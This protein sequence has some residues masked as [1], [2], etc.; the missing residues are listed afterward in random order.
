[1]MKERALI[2]EMSLDQ[3]FAA[4]RMVGEQPEMNSVT[5]QFHLIGCD[6]ELGTLTV[7]RNPAATRWMTTVG[8]AQG[9]RYY[10][11][12]AHGQTASEALAKIERYCHWWLGM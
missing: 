10:A 9:A 4:A 7:S 11:R 8:I 5:I 1:M 3:L 6:A 12:M 2:A